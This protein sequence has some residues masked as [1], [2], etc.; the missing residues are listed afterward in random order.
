MKNRERIIA[1]F[2]REKI[3]RIVWQP[4]IEHWYNVNRSRGTL[5]EEYK[6]MGLI[7]IYDDLDASIRYTHDAGSFLKISYYGDIRVKE[8][9]NSNEIIVKWVAPQGELIQRYKRAE[10]GFSCHLV[11]YPVKRIEDIKVMEYILRHKR[12]EFDYKVYEK[13]KKILGDRGVV[14]FWVERSPLQ[15]LILDYMGFENAIYALHDY[16]NR[17]KRFL[18]VIEETDNPLYQVIADCP[19]NFQNFGENI[20]SNLDSPR[21]Y[22]EYLLPYYKKRVKRMHKK[23]KF[24]H[25]HMDGSLKAILPYINEAGFDGIEAATPLLQG[26]VSLEEIKEAIGNTMLLDGIPAILFL[27]HYSYKELENFTLK[28]LEIFSPNLIMGVSDEL[29]PDGDIKKVKLVSEIVGSFKVKQ[30]TDSCIS[31]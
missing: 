25:I 11:E 24:C 14:Q 19:C 23:H 2:K 4:R 31:G 9:W 21:L 26:D 17:I 1:T 10:F 8:E 12:V 28:V 20:D 5:P 30:T 13:A 18:R 22:N 29:P 3:D 27:S 15:R 16:S 6:N 7:E